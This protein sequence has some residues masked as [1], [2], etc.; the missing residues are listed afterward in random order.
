M[1]SL[2]YLSYE[3]FSIQPAKK[4]G[5]V[6]CNNIEGVSL[7]L[8]YSQQCPH[9]NDIFP[10]F[11]NLP[12]IIPQCKF[13]LLNINKNEQVAHMSS[14][15]I[16]PITYVPFMIL[17]VN[18]R[19]AMKYNG[20]KTTTAI[21]QFVNEVLSRLKMKTSFTQNSRI[22]SLSDTIPEY[23]SGIPFNLVCEGEQC[24]LNFSEAY[25]R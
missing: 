7:V 18:G 14:K 10:H 24:Y 9:C 21:S 1:D 22:D 4:G 16:A 2:K 25:K 19:P 11:K 5:H 15:T 12:R 23:A 3:D 20:E 6:L 17:Y 13:A 8:I